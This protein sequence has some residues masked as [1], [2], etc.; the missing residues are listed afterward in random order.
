[1][2]AFGSYLR[3]SGTAPAT[4]PATTTDVLNLGGSFK[5]GVAH[6]GWTEGQTFQTGLTFVFAPNTFTPY[7]N[8]ADGQTYDVDWV[9][10]L[11]G[12][13]TTATSYDVMTAR[14]YHSGGVNA[15]FMD[16][17]IRFTANSVDPAVW[18]AMGT[19]SGGEPASP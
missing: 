4:P 16:G 7:L 12:S 1:M 2:K 14:S 19:R 17:S 11:D 13:S 9:S 15:L 18:R 5:P 8:P 10:G 6:T 3:G